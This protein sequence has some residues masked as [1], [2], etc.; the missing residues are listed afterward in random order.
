[1]AATGAG[2][3]KKAAAGSSLHSKTLLRSEQLYQVTL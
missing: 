1:M 3:G 2:E